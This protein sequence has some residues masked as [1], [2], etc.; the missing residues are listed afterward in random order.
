MN[1]GIPSS[2]FLFIPSEWSD[3]PSRGRG[4]R[5][6]IKVLPGGGRGEKEE[7]R[8]QRSKKSWRRAEKGFMKILA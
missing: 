8:G 2:N 3:T 7:E 4:L 5:F 1:V 6:G